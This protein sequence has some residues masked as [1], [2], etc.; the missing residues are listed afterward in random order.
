[1]QQ[2]VYIMAKKAIFMIDVDNGKNMNLKS[3]SYCK[4]FDNGINN[5]LH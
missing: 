5:Y 2:N 3:V 4:H 1:M